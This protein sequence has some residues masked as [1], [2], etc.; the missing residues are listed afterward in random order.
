MINKDRL[1]ISILIILLM[2]LMIL[3]I[4]V[5]RKVREKQNYINQQIQY[6]IQLEEEKN[7]FYKEETMHELSNIVNFYKVKGCVERY[8]TDWSHLYLNDEE[9]FL[10]DEILKEFVNLLAEN[11]KKEYPINKDNFS[12][13]FDKLDVGRIM[14]DKIYEC[15]FKEGLSSYL[16]SG[17]NISNVDFNKKYFR[18]ML[19]I[20][21]NQNTFEIYPDEYI[22]QKGIEKLEPNND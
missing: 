5:Y 6:K 15:K 20:D 7:K 10:K 2:I 22:K 17:Y 8:Y 4:I 21:T 18:I 13:V 14:Y 1:L 11:Y 9:Q 19:I 16:I 3:N 12:S